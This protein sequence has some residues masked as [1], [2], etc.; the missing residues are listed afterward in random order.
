MKKAGVVILSILTGFLL[1]SFAEV[2][3][4]GRTARSMVDSLEQERQ[5]AVDSIMHALKGKENSPADSV[6]SNLQTFTGSQR[7][8]VRH[9]MGVMGY[10]AEALGVGCNYCHAKTSWSSD[11]LRTKKVA[12]QMYE[13]RSTINSQILGKMTDLTSKTPVVNCGTCHRGHAIPPHD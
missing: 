10:W 6:F 11:E 2:S 12:R 3:G 7:L 4:G 9:L 8:R 1:L 5:K 13:M